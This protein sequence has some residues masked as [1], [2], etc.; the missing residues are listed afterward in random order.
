MNAFKKLIALLLF[1]IFSS[2]TLAAVTDADVFAYASANYPAIFAGSVSTGNVQNY[3]YSYYATSKNYLAVNAG[4]I[5]IMG[6]V[7]GGVIT[8]VGTVA[9]FAPA[10]TAWKATQ[11]PTC[12]APQVLTN[13]VCVAPT[14]LP[15]G[16][17]SQGGLTWMPESSTLY[18]YAQATALC[19]GTIN[20][21]TGWRL[22]TQ[23]ELSAL[24]SAYPDTSGYGAGNSPLLGQ[25][26]TLTGAWSS[27]P[28]P[29]PFPAGFYYGVYL[30]NGT[31]YA[32]RDANRNTGGDLWV[33]NVT[34]V[35]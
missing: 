33:G 34:C 11:V 27:T 2:S 19:A 13:G 9:S 29:S 17:V 32:N 3:D 12:T 15:A 35:R 10:I 26:W 18:S 5:Y 21:Q 1:S 8:S 31:L 22:P 20:G 7:S 16:Y 6:P 28:I 25:G 24:Y 23:P 4:T 30:N 14:A